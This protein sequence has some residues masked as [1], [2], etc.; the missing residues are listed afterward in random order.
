MIIERLRQATKPVHAQL[1]HTVFPIIRTVRSVEDYSRLLQIFYGFFKPMYDC[2][3]IYLQKDKLTDYHTRRKP[4]R[5]L[6]DLFVLTGKHSDINLCIHVPVIT[7]SAQAFGCMYVLE[8]STMGGGILCKRIAE[9][10]GFADRHSLSFFHGYGENNLSMWSLFLQAMENP[11][12][13]ESEEELIDAAIATFK[14]FHKWITLQ[15]TPVR[16]HQV[17][18]A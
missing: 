16:S 14:S 5:I 4:E 6:E 10:L 3:D 11:A 15:Y 13:E 2:L 8:G 9:N 18:A 17:Q 7:N 1:D 12:N